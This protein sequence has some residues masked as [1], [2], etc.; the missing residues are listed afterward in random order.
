MGNDIYI[1]QMTAKLTIDKAGRVV[2]PKKLRDRM[3]LAAGD[4]FELESTDDQIVLKP[5]REEPTMFKK[6]G[7]WVCR[8]GKP[9]TLEETNAVLQT[10]R[11]E[12]DLQNMGLM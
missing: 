10:I 12:R 1:T 2:I 5:V 8:T 7:I 6:S 4:S 9:M 3:H 11:D